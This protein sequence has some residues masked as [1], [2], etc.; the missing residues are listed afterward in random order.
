[1][2]KKYILFAAVAMATVYGC[3]KNDTAAPK[4]PTPPTPSP[5]AEVISSGISGM[6]VDD[7]GAPVSG[8]TVTS[9]TATAV[10]DANG[11]FTIP[12]ASMRKAAGQ[13]TVE[14][15]G[16]LTGRRAFAAV[17]TNM[18]YVYVRLIPKQA[19]QTFNAATGGTINIS[20]GSTIVFEPASIINS[21]NNNAYTGTVNISAQFIDPKNAH[22]TENMPG[23]F[24]GMARNGGLTGVHSS[25]I[26]FIELTGNN[27]EKLQ[28]N[29]DLPATLT[30][31][32]APADY[33]QAPAT[34]RLSRLADSTGLWNEE[35]VALKQLD[36]YVG[37]VDHFSYWSFGTHY[38]CLQISTPVKNNADK[39]A[40]NVLGTYQYSFEGSNYTASSYADTSGLLKLWVPANV[41]P[42]FKIKSPGGIELH[43]SQPGP[44]WKDSTLA[45]IK[46]AL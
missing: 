40:P 12:T 2:K 24:L 15:A 31:P 6:I 41:K 35:G 42:D 19:A 23:S 30:L 21:A 5:I 37:K 18:Q 11:A 29:K 3:N 25:A 45:T 39:A 9:G 28:L 13:I 43:S 20:N 46:V 1:M 44:F 27:G 22:F 4:P 7:A 8:A 33:D 26:L 14:K 34:L 16:F 32:I 10:T 38:R 36:K 17:A